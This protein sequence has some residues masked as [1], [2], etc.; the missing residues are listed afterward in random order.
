M[1]M[2]KIKLNLNDTLAVV[3]LVFFTIHQIFYISKGGTTWDDFAIY[4]TTNR[5]LSKAQLF[6]TDR[7]NPFLGDFDF[8]LEF[9]GYFVPIIIFFLTELI[10][11][12]NF[13]QLFLTEVLNAEIYN[14]LDLIFVLRN[15]LISFYTVIVLTFIYRLLSKKTNKSFGLSFLIFLL[16][17]PS[18]NGHAMF[19]IKDIPFLLHYFLAALLILDFKIYEIKIS[20]NSFFRLI[21]Y[22]LIFGLVVLVRFN[23]YAFLLMLSFY[24]FLTKFKKNIENFKFVLFNWSF[25]YLVSFI[26]LIL[27]SPSAWGK[28]T[29]WLKGLYETQFN[30][31]WLGS[32]LTNGTYIKATEMESSYLVSWFL[33]KLPLNLLIGFILF[34]LIFIFNKFNFSNISNFSLYFI[35]LVFF[36]FSIFRPIAYDG[37][38]QFLFLIPFFVILFI[39]VLNYLK[40]YL[41]FNIYLIIFLISVGYL[42]YTQKSLGEYKYVYFNEIVNEE[43]VSI[44]CNLIGGCGKWETD[45]WGYSIKSLS[46]DFLEIE[47]IQ[48]CEPSHIFNI[49]SKQKLVNL[50][51][52]QVYIASLNRK[53]DYSLCPSFVYRLTDCAIYSK[54]V[55]YL[56][57]HEVNLSFIY[58]CG[59]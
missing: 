26:F 35:I 34:I 9:Y 10:L 4:Y 25:I 18:F 20:K 2:N 7:S 57:G 47:N 28:P 8:N 48:F 6:F 44:N 23:G 22:G 59:K 56:R 30:I 45:Y 52:K 21:F 16:L 41:S 40:K 50:E 31:D 27:F 33:H 29:T 14:K 13:F 3:T 19:N 54:E 37:I 49:Y 43:E 1:K 17:T 38:R 53:L 15:V 5:I 51:T 42:I 32:T 58:K 11:K 12:Y 36:T 39:E 24:M 55:A 46:K